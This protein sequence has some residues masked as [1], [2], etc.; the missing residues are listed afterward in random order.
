MV[1]GP[2]RLPRAAPRDQRGSGFPGTRFGMLEFHSL[3]G[4]VAQSGSAPRSHRGGLGFKSPQVHIC[5]CLRVS[6]GTRARNPPDRLDR[7]GSSR[8]GPRPPCPPAAAPLSR[9]QTAD[10][11]PGPTPRGCSVV[12]VRPP[13]RR[14]APGAG[15]ARGSGLAGRGD[16]RAANGVGP[17]PD[18]G[19]YGPG[20]R[21]CARSANG[22]GAPPSGPPC[23]LP[24]RPSRPLPWPLSRPLSCSPS[25]LR[26]CRPSSV[27]GI[28]SAGSES[29]MQKRKSG[30]TLE[31]CAAEYRNLAALGSKGT[32]RLRPSGR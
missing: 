1:H 9:P 29:P 25:R 23:P 30:R 21:E 32:R 4:P 6:P 11:R 24:C 31:N 7:A 2:G 22:V 20:A 8:S 28:P 26:S 17:P 14:G 16:I 18:G 3:Q 27:P 5:N 13:G 15:A 12:A 19:G 10:R